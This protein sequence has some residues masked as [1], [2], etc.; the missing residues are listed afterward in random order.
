MIC[1][2]LPPG[3]VVKLTCSEVGLCIV[4]DIDDIEHTYLV[5]D[6]NFPAKNV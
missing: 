3:R 6:S 1:S 5:L 4:P 2:L